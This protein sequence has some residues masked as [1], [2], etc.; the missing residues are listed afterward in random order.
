[1][2][3]VRSR[4][5]V[6]PVWSRSGWTP[7]NLLYICLTDLG[8]C[9]N[10]IRPNPMSFCVCKLHI[11]MFTL[12]DPP[13]SLPLFIGLCNTELGIKIPPEIS[14]FKTLNQ[15]NA[16]RNPSIPCNYHHVKVSHGAKFLLH[17][18]S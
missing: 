17:V 7:E 4:L 10:P 6:R 14:I 12:P 18:T 8:L 15:V 5:I 3:V 16:K 13:P 2:P 1:M 9:L 11:Y